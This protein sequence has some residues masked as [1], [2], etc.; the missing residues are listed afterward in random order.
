[1]TK[2]FKLTAETWFII[3][4]IAALM[5]VWAT[6]IFILIGDRP[7]T[8]NHGTVPV[9]P[10]DSYYT[11]GAAPAGAPKQVDLPPQPQGGSR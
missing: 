7:P 4:A 6:T 11:A 5:L 1:M 10:G 3:A 8:W 2:E 9:V